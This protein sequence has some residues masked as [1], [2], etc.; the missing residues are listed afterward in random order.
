MT[1]EKLER[2]EFFGRP[3]KHEMTI[4]KPVYDIQT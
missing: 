2:Y 3:L 4:G 1:A